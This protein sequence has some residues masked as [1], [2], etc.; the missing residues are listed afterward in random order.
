MNIIQLFFLKSVEEKVTDSESNLDTVVEEER[1]QRNKLA[2]VQKHRTIGEQYRIPEE[3]N[4]YTLNI[5]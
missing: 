1:E 5:L 4:L 3:S 2:Q